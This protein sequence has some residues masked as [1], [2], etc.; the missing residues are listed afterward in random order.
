ML[1]L[2][3]L[4]AS[5]FLITVGG[6]R[7]SSSRTPTPVS[8]SAPETRKQWDLAR[9]AWLLD[10]VAAAQAA[11]SRFAESN[12]QDPRSGEA[13]L[14]AGICAQRRGRNKEADGLLRE[15]QSRGGA[16]AAR[17]LLQRGYLLLPEQPVRAISCFA[18]AAEKALDPETRAE[19]WLQHGQA[20]QRSGRFEKAAD[21][22]NRCSDQQDAPGLAARAKLLLQYDPWFTVQVGAF[23][24]RSNAQRQ[25]R[26]LESAG[27]PAEHRMPGRRGSP[28]HRVLSGRFD[29]RDAAIR[30]S[31]RIK[32]VLGTEDVKVIP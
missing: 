15:A 18:E 19:G 23:L 13:L 28:L 17:A 9:T 27:L 32:Q 25:L 16:V 24:D 2:L 12:P 14:T 30:H 31:L 20:L 21:P 8:T 6:C 4:L 22:L 11:F 5:A 1:A 3:L 7:N 26:K 10:D 29:Q